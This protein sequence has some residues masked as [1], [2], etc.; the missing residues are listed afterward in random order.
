[1]DLSISKH[2]RVGD[3]PEN[4]KRYE[5]SFPPDHFT[6][7]I[8]PYS[9]LSNP[10]AKIYESSVFEAGG[11]KWRLS[12][13]PNETIDGKGYISLYLAL[14]S[15][16]PST[17]LTLRSIFPGSRKPVD[18]YA[19]FR[20]FVFNNKS[21][22]DKYLTVEDGS[23][24][25]RPFNERRTQ[26]WGF[27]KF[28]PRSTFESQGYLFN[29]C[30]TFGAEVFVHKNNRKISKEPFI[31]WKPTNPMRAAQFRLES[32]QSKHD[33]EYLSPEFTLQGRKWKLRVCPRGEGKKQK[34]KS[35][36]L[37]LRL[38]EDLNTLPSICAEFKLRVLDQVRHDNIEKT[39]SHWFS[40]SNCEH[41]CQ[42][43]MPLKTLQDSSK[44][45]IQ[46]D[47]LSVEVEILAISV[48]K[49]PATTNK[50]PILVIK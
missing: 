16:N 23:G 27:A 18:V 26:E 39:V 47:A 22:E 6:M 50:T 33:P 32:F 43:F 36:S 2:D 21:V 45:F 34:D 31:L 24:K 42:S 35:L 10:Q 38:T 48:A 30:C 37:F 25:V 49:A 17:S 5:R 44:G 20:L 8:K 28:L 3:I 1:M 7:E 4:I 29:D 15:T 12:L 41:G 46:D 11:Y 9:L 40:S 14:A 19:T 13:Y